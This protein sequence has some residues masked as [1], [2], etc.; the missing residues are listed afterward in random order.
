MA[1]ACNVETKPQIPGMHLF[2]LRERKSEPI[3]VLFWLFN[4]SFSEFHKWNYI[5]IVIS[6]SHGIYSYLP[7]FEIV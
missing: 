1:D 2:V 3:I 7:F 4:F 5:V 6:G